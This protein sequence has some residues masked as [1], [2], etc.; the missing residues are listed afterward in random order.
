M[1]HQNGISRVPK[2][3]GDTA[4]WI[5]LLNSHDSL[6]TQALEVRRSLR[7]RN[8]R[9]VT[10]DFVLLEVA[11]GLCQPPLRKAVIGVIEELRRE[12]T[13][14]IVPLSEQLMEKGW[15]LYQ[16]RPDKEWGLTDCISF[17]VMQE[18]GI[19]EAFTSDHHFT[20]AGFVI[21]LSHKP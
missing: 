14:D 17:V 9:V 18:Q 7:Q 20:Q 8:V 21:L 1:A 16:Q 19:T 4:S 13:I 12:P 2:V 5:A 10:T 6:H 3:F 15:Q 11:D